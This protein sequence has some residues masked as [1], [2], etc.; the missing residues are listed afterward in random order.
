MRNL[1]EPRKN[2][3][4]RKDEFGKDDVR[5]DDVRKDEMRRDDIRRDEAR[6]PEGEVV[7]FEQ[8]TAATQET[9]MQ[10]KSSIFPK[11]EADQFRSRWNAIQATFVDEPRN[12]IEEADKLVASAI[13]RMN[14][15]YS[16]ER[17]K[18]E[19]AWKRGEH[20][21][22]EDLRITLQH[23]RAFFGRVMST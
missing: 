18:M 10:E 5:K 11:N 7:P 16:E 1:N 22:T 13:Q 19:G 9:S 6:K 14:Q 21:S 15:V 8:R 17:A 2:D 3:E 12:A 20:V 4:I 23:Y